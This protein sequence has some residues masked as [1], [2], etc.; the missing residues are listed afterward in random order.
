MSWKEVLG[1]SFFL[2]VVILLSLYWFFPFGD[3]EFKSSRSVNTN[4]TINSSSKNMQFYENM[5]YPNKTISYR[6][7]DCTLQKTDEMERAIQEIENL[8]ILNFYKVNNNAVP[9]ASAKE[10][11]LITCDSGARF[12]GEFFVAGEGGPTKI[13]KSKNFNVIHEGA[14][15]LIRPSKCE[16]PLIALHELLH[17]LGFD[18]SDNP[19][20]IMYPVSE[21]GQKIGKDMIDQI[22]Y[23]YS[24]PSYSDLTFENASALMHGRY[25]DLA[26]T[27]N[28][29]GLKNSEESRLII[30]ADNKSI[31]EFKIES[32]PINAG[33]MIT[34]KNLLIL[35]TR[36]NEIE[37][38]LDTGF[39]ELDKNNNR[40]FL[41]VK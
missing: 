31:K 30:Y 18:H 37:L 5:R 25:L 7:E 1:F 35:Q 27:I 3:T 22:N 23:L 8:T 41:E 20:N 16:E 9:K 26:L 6:I 32:V 33:R 17:A 13:T 39:P 28:N 29:D 11:I 36:V 21:C 40:L 38:F 2:V 10:E 19:E 15:T 24:F 34:L 4:F 12:E 14:V